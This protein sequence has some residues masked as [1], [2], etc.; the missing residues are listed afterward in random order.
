MLWCFQCGVEYAP[1]VLD[2]L[3]CG[4]ALVEEAPA[5]VEMVGTPDEEQL[6]YELH[7]WAGESR[8][9]LDQ[10]LTGQK[11][12]HA[13]QGAAL[14]VRVAD[15]EVVD[16]FLVAARPVGGPALDPNADKIVYELSDWGSDDQTA[17][18][19]LLARLGITH[20]F[21]EV[22]DLVI[23]AADEDDVESAID[24]FESQADG[25]PELDGVD[26][27]EMLSDLFVACDRLRNNPLDDL[28]VSGVLALAPP[29]GYYRPPFGIDTRTWDA[30]ASQ[31]AHLVDLLTAGN[32]SQGDIT[33][34]A[35][36]LKEALR[37]LV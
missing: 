13:W 1:G 29:L 23:L 9:L 30:L 33:E 2:C 14:I 27:N 26:G 15:E 37:L 4:L 25:R 17:F 20:Q 24:T 36:T 22:G 18:S 32:A 3:E 35:T 7:E 21:D 11:I 6:I 8:R 12:D 28:G 31:A 16:D 34:A 10:L 19:D 5:S